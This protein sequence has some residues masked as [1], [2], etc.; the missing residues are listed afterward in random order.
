[1]DNTPRI[2]TISLMTPGHPAIAADGFAPRLSC[3]YGGLF[4]ALGVQMP[5]L[6]VWLAAKGLDANAIGL[7]L[8]APLI[9]RVVAVPLVTGLAD[10]FGALRGALIAAAAATTAGYAVLGLADG[11]WPILMM[12]ALASAA[13]TSIFPLS[14]AYALKGLAARGRS[15][16][17]VRL[18]GSGTF[19]LGSLGA[20]LAADAVRPADLVWLMAAAFLLMALFS[21]GLPALGGPPAPPSSRPASAVAFLRSPAFLVVAAAAGLIQ[22][23]HALYYGFS[24]LAWTAAGFDGRT[25]GALWAIG[26]IAEIVLFAVSGRLPA[27]FGPTAFLCAG[28]AG[29]A[30]RWGAMA[31][32]PPA[33]ALPFLQCLHGLSFGA[34]HLGSVQFLARAAPDRLGATAQGYLAIV[35]GVVMAAFMGFSGLIY[36]SYGSRGYAVMALAALAGGAVALAAHRWRPQVRGVV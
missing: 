31:I 33:L 28:A 32:D 13:F 15:Y 26:V 19:I 18:W 21:L 10:R 3:F 17:S 4:M 36:A 11:F 7:V 5:F 20:G 27:A 29:A 22:A 12:V 25:I 9:L 24:T 35:L 30:V 6:P 14:D 8:A 16:G 34:T 1:L 23:S 2:V